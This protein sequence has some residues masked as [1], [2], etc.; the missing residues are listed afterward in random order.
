MLTTSEI[1]V[2]IT[3]WSL[4]VVGVFFGVRATV[5]KKRLKPEA[6]KSCTSEKI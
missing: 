5:R 6:S 1:A 2:I 3:I 4:T